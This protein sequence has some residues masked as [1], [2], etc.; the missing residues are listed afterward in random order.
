M[1]QFTVRNIEDE[2]KNLLKQRA[3]RNRTSLE[4]EVRDILRVAVLNQ[5]VSSG[6]GLGS[7][8]AARFAKIGLTDA[9]ALPELRG[10]KPRPIKL[11]P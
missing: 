5:P 8:I 11:R 10:Q 6:P 4:A 3:V 2:V 7:R 1:A 9:E